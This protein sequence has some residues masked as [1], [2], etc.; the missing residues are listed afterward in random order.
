VSDRPDLRVVALAPAGT[1]FLS[2]WR[3]P[4]AVLATLCA[5]GALVLVFARTFRREDR[6]RPVRPVAATEPTQ[7][8]V[9]Q[10]PPM[11]LA[12]LGEQLAAANDVEALLRVILDAAI[13]A[14]GASGGKVARPGEAGTRAGESDSDVLRV[15]LHTN[16]PEG[17]SALLL[18]P[19]PDGFSPEA[20]GIAHW[21]GTHAGTAIRD[22]RF[23]RVIQAQETNDV[24]TGLADR[25]QLTT[26]LE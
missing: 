6:R 25:K 11:P 17:D 20:A 18:Y 13:K 19:P 2:A 14:T 5:V 24:L 3:L 7:E 26:T 8:P 12:M 10:Q 21:L 1:R 4:L 15:P 22:A 9:A 16:D 23:H